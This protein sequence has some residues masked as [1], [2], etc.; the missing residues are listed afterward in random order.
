ERGTLGYVTSPNIPHAHWAH[1]DVVTL[2]YSVNVICDDRGSL[3][4]RHN[5]VYEPFHLC[6]FCAL[7]TQSRP[8]ACKLRSGLLA[9]DRDGNGGRVGSLYLILAQ[10]DVGDRQSDLRLVVV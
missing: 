1:R 8:C 7:V 2:R 9:L 10:V 3:A 4:E 6:T 5:V